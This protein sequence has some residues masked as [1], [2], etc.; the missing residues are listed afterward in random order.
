MQT[1]DQNQI[2]PD[3]PRIRP[4]TGGQWKYCSS[5]ADIAIF[6]GVAGASKTW[7]LLMQPLRHL[8][9]SGF[10]AV[11]FRRTSKQVMEPGALWDAAMEIYPRF[12]GVPNMGRMEF[13]FPPHGVRIAF[14]HLEHEQ[15]RLN[16]D[17]SQIAFI[18][19]DQLES[20]TER[21]WSYL[22]SR[23]RSTCG[24]RPY[25]R[26]TA[27]PVPSGLDPGGWLHDLIA[28]WIDEE[29]GLIVPEKSGK[30][31]WFIT[32]DSEMQ[33]ADSAEELCERFPGAD[34]PQSLTFILG[35][36]DEN[37]KMLELDPGYKARMARL[38]R[39][40]YARLVLGDWNARETA[41]DFFQGSWF[42]VVDA[43]PPMVSA[44]R[45][46]DRAASEN[47]PSGSWTAGVLMGKDAHAGYWVLD[48]VRMQGRPGDVQRAI[49]NTATKDGN[50]VKIGIEQDPGQAGVAEAESHV[51]RLAE[52]GY[53]S[54]AN[55]VRESKAVRV[56]PYSSMAQVGGVKL[57]RGAWNSA[58][59]RE[60]E[61][62]DGSKKCM[63][64]QVDASSGAFHMLTSKQTSTAIFGAGRG[65]R[66]G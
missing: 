4:Q 26:A 57:V 33:W 11:I 49:D 48:V 60:L 38:S 36:L 22:A 35:K 34:E 16:W 62:Y 29:S 65:V 47:N 10:N 46:W 59:L 50:R 55:A 30:L 6:G 52:M 53:N 23:N 21:Q 51:K 54:A 2:H 66:V 8:H 19:W 14:A 37:R 12:G 20:F 56:R 28:W 39:V 63:A 45:Y 42:S 1:P 7:G 27:N 9:V 24:V 15:D 64:D 25:I 32:Y 41:G 5:S 17:G 44:I 3:L 40:D 43:A 31:R 13:K 58:Y 18:G 61:N